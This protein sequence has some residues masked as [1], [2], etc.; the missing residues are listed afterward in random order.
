MNIVKN[1]IDS[2][3]AVLKIQINKADYEERVNNVLKDYRKKANM[4]GFRPGKVPE[5]LVKK[6]YGSSALLDEINKIISESLSKYILDNKLNLLGEPIPSEKEQKEINWGHQDDFEF[7]FEI[8]TAPEFDLKLSKKDKVTYYEID[9]DKKTIAS[10]TE[11]FTNRY[12]ALAPAK[13]VEDDSVLKGTFV[14]LNDANE[15]K[16]GGVLAEDV[17]VSLRVVKEE[18]EKAKFVGKKINDVINVD[19]IKAFPNNVDLSAMLKIDK[20]RL[21]EINN[22]FQFTIIEIQKFQPAKIDQDLFDKAFGKDTIKSVEEF[23]ARI[24]E[25][26]KKTLAQESDYKLMID[27]K[28]KLLAKADFELPDGFLKKWLLYINKEKFTAEQIE[29]EYHH[30]QEDLKW[31]L[32]KE[33][34]IKENAISITE[35]DILDSAKQFAKM[36]FQQYGLNDIP[37]EYLENYAKEI[38]KKD[39]EKR[40]IIERK[41]EEKV[42]EFVKEVIK[43]ESKKVSPDEFNKLF[44]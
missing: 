10:Y 43:I 22:N 7:A 24:Q 21:N 13:K 15:I 4:P 20:S 18:V 14:E 29:T 39:D 42:I 1:E 44:E 23:N 38:I 27:T 11:S 6:M 2:L 17:T 33:K 25:E 3:N 37:E 34:M 8:A 28:A 41:Y 9:P 32:I 30:F 16:K 40:K 26:I 12:G 31:Q 36:Q 19:V 5:G 35:D